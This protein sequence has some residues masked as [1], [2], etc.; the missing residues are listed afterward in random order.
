MKNDGDKCVNKI[1]DHD[2]NKDCYNDK[3]FDNCNGAESEINN[4]KIYWVR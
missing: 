3:N 2:N 1:I 4:D